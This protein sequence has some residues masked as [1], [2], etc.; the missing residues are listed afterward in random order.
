MGEEGLAPVAPGGGRVSLKVEGDGIADN[1]G[2]D[3]V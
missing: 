3:R 1:G 2:E